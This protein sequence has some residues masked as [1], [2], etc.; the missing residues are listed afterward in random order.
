MIDLRRFLETRLGGTLAVGRALGWAVG[1]LS[2][3][4]LATI[5]CDVAREGEERRVPAGSGTA[6]RK[7]RCEANAAGAYA[8]REVG[9][10]A[11][12]VHDAV[13]VADSS[14]IDLTLTGQQITAAAIFGTTAGTVREGNNAAFPD[15]TFR[16]QDNS[17]A[18]KQAAFE[19][20]GISTGT[21]RT[22]T[23][24]D[25]SGTIALMGDIGLVF[26]DSATF[27]AASSVSLDGVF[28]S[29]YRNY[30]I[31]LSLSAVSAATANI[32]LR[33]RAGGSTVASANYERYHMLGISSGSTNFPGNA[34]GTTGWIVAIAYSAYGEASSS[35]DL[36]DPAQNI[37]TR[38][39]ATSVQMRASNP[40]VEGYWAAL[41]L[42]LTTAYDGFAVLP[43]SGTIT[44]EVRVY[45]YRS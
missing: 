35:I 20:S 39:S 22:L 28:T 44:G 6:S 10:A 41:G 12:N 45:G 19:A 21:T 29:A 30:R 37:R 24:P 38:A 23:I 7:V 27:S 25:A 36:F 18:T 1:E 34:T 13:T 33:M 3:A 43:D 5:P 9:H 14:S 42:R 4:E 8:W 40:H 2:S 26:I 15:N 32:L 31:M 16:I 11:L 17:D